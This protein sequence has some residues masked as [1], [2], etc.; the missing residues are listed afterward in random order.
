MILRE[1]SAYSMAAYLICRKKGY[2]CILYNQNPLW[3]TPAKTDL[4]HRIV[5]SMTPKLRMTPVMGVKRPGTSVKEHDFFR[6]LCDRAAEGRPEERTYFASDTVHI[7]CI[8]KYEPRKHHLLLL[9]V[10]EEL[11]GGRAHAPAGKLPD[12]FDRR[13]AQRRCGKRICRRK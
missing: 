1:R 4:A 10:V 13:S 2:P 8:G 12:R 9:Q 11:L 7:L 5:G 3:S 6:P